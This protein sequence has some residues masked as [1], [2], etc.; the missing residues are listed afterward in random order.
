MKC[1][2]LFLLLITSHSSYSAEQAPFDENTSAPNSPSM[3]PLIKCLN[4]TN[5]SDTKEQ[6]R[7][8]S[9]LP[10]VPQIN[11]KRK[12]HPDSDSDDSDDDDKDSCNPVKRATIEQ[13]LNPDMPEQARCI[14]EDE[15]R[16]IADNLLQ[17]L[18]EQST[19][20]KSG[21]FNLHSQGGKSG[22][23]RSLHH[24]IIPYQSSHVKKKPLNKNRKGPVI[25]GRVWKLT[26]ENLAKFNRHRRRQRILFNLRPITETPVPS[27]YNS[28]IE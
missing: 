5:L 27:P 14:E 23:T 1:C 21:L 13:A 11:L 18:R 4:D 20:V 12:N 15:K 25:L 10:S 16:A 6:D 2:L 26:K 22:K 17:E 3:H 19:I 9:S 8:F 24:V 28:D 7:P